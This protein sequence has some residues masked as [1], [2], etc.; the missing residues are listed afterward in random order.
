MCPW[1]IHHIGF[2]KRLTSMDHDGTWDPLF[3]TRLWDRFEVVIYINKS[4]IYRKL[5]DQSYL[6]YIQCTSIKNGEE[7]CHER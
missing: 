5:Y 7:L 2:A 4:F 6:I 1:Q 3:Y